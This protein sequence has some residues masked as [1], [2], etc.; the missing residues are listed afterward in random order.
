MFEIQAL[1]GLVDSDQTPVGMKVEAVLTLHQRM[2]ARACL[3]GWSELGRSHA[4]HQ[5]EKLR[6]AGV[7]VG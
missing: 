4:R 7:L 6:E 2:D 3:C 1:Q 5:M